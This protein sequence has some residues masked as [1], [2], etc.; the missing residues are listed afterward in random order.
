MDFKPVAENDRM[1]AKAVAQRP[2]T[3]SMYAKEVFEPLFILFIRSVIHSVRC[4]VSPPA[5]DY[6]DYRDL[7][8]K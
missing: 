1:S 7:V 5:P 6:I 8:P 2:V 4:S 3:Q